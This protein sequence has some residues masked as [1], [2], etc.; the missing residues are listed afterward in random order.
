[1]IAEN[2]RLVTNWHFL[3]PWWGTLWLY[4]SYMSMASPS[5][6]YIKNKP[7]WADSDGLNI[8]LTVIFQQLFDVF[9]SVSGES[10]KQAT[11]AMLCQQLSGQMHGQVINQFPGGRTGTGPQLENLQFTYWGYNCVCCSLLCSGQDSRDS[12][13]LC[14]KMPRTWQPFSRFNGMAAASIL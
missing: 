12:F 10:M 14:A 13:C 4:G 11:I 8:Y 6:F 1:M 3:M 5:L 2:W 9:V 7:G